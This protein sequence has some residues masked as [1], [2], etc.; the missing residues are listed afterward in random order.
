VPP[1]HIRPFHRNDRDQ[2]TELVNAHAAAVVPGMGTSVAA[3]LA[4]LERDPGEPITDPWV[5]RRV[6]LVA[7]QQ[8]RVVAAAHLLGYGDD[9]RVDQSYRRL[10]EIGWLVFWPEAPAG[11]RHWADATGAAEKLMA[12]CI[13]QFEAWEVTSQSAAGDLPVLCG[14]YGVPEQ[15]PHVAALYQRAGFR[16]AGHSEII[17]LAPV[18]GLPRPARP[19]LDGLTV[20]RSVGLSGTRLAAVRAEED[21]GHIEVDIRGKGERLSPHGRWADIGNLHV[22][23][24]YRR[25]GVGTWLLGQ[26][27]GWLE[28]AQVHNLLDYCYA[29]RDNPDHCDPAGR[30]AFLAATGFRRL[31]LTRRGWNRP[32]AG[33]GAG[34][35]R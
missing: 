20:R 11:N 10:G 4:S 24:E 21:L 27:A 33:P 3:L 26:A 1:V 14:V 23:S 18:A 5:A 7:E 25:R 19:P 30:Q 28:L 29:D 34:R 17:Y 31:T 8:H 16:P 6:T 2:L 15:W 32:G 13:A 12:A 9:E 22:T 35:R